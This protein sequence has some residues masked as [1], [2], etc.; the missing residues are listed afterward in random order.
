MNLFLEN[1]DIRKK[2]LIIKSQS[3]FF[4]C[5]CCCCFI[6]ISLLVFPIFC[7]NLMWNR[8]FDPFSCLIFECILI[9]KLVWL[10]FRFTRI[11]D[12][13][14]FRNQSLVSLSQSKV[15]YIILVGKICHYNF[16]KKIILREHF[17]FL[18]NPFL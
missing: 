4:C 11:W 1:L 6:T 13:T 18:V 3:V 17:F 12:S 15:D 14:L 16:F 5:C 10:T 2:L 7:I 8:C 9:D